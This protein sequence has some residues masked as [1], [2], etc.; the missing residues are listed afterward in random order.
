[1]QAFTEQSYVFK[2]L[3]GKMPE[4]NI[5]SFSQN[6]SKDMIIWSPEL[7]LLLKCLE[8]GQVCK[9]VILV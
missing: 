6:D 4:T 1:M 5:F 3:K 9:F 2:S 7:M 8:I